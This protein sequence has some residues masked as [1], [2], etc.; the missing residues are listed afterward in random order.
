LPVISVEPSRPNGAPHRFESG[1]LHWQPVSARR[2]YSVATIWPWLHQ[3]KHRVRVGES[4]RS[5]RS[6]RAW[7][8]ARA[9]GVSASSVTSRAVCSK[10]DV[11]RCWADRPLGSLLD[12]NQR[13]SSLSGSRRTNQSTAGER[14]RW[15]ARSPGGSPQ[16]VPASGPAAG[17][18]WG[19]SV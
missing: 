7:R 6:V 2:L 12:K 10:I 3:E 18:R 19:G 16:C 14:R 1:Q 8:S 5:H 13:K 4:P 15:W 9:A 11:S 17:P